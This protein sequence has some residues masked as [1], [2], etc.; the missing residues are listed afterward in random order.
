MVRLRTSRK[1][2]GGSAAH[3]AGRTVP[4]CLSLDRSACPWSR[5]ATRR[6]ANGDRGERAWPEADLHRRGELRSRHLAHTGASVALS[7]DAE[8]IGAG[9]TPETLGLGRDR[10]SL[11]VGRRG[12]A[13]HERRSVD[14]RRRATGLSRLRLAR[15]HR[16]HDHHSKPSHVE[17]LP[18]SRSGRAIAVVE[19]HG[20]RFFVRTGRGWLRNWHRRPVVAAR[21]TAHPGAAL[22]SDAPVSAGPAALKGREPSV[23][24]RLAERVHWG[25]RP[26][27]GA[28]RDRDHHH[29]DPAHAASVGRRAPFRN[30]PHFAAPEVRR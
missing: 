15:D 2:R 10:N 8:P 18:P 30:A 23:H 6:R 20:R 28:S 4:P 12:P 14:H 9:G 7:T 25:I 16:D 1:L 13:S 21:P 29:T 11:F 17:L 3:G 26:G 5:E 24:A 22:R 27:V 19:H